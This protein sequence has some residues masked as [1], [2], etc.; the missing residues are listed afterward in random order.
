VLDFSVTWYDYRRLSGES[1]TPFL[2]G[3]AQR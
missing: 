3:A 2:D 1:V